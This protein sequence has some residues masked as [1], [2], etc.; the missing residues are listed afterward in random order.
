ME[1][2]RADR[3]Q[4]GGHECDDGEAEQVMGMLVR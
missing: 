3:E 1:H 2:R 4:V